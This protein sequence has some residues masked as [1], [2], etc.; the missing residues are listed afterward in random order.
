MLRKIAIEPSGLRPRGSVK[1]RRDVVLVLSQLWGTE[2]ATP[3]AYLEGTARMA[4]P[5]TPQ[6]AK[7]KAAE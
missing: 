4:H 7:K 6:M 3:E 5:S 1:R 2:G